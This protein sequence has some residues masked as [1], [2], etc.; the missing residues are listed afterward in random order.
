MRY[1]ILDRAHASFGL[2]IDAE[3][4]WG[5]VDE[6]SMPARVDETAS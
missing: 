3:P 2:M 4:H 6:V 5:R 1:R